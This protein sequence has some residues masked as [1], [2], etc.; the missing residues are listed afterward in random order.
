MVIDDSTEK[1]RGGDDVAS[2]WPDAAAVLGTPIDGK[3]PGTPRLG[4][5]GGSRSSAFTDKLLFKIDRHL[6]VP[7]FFLN[8]LSLMGRT[9]IGA[10]LIQ[11]LPQDLH[12]DAMG[13]FL[14]LTMPVAPLILCEVPS[15][16]LMR[17]LE[18]KWRFPYMRYLC[19]IDI[20]LGTCFSVAIKVC[21]S[22]HP[23]G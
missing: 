14:V 19:V 18:R 21:C 22:Q 5:G 13:V 3:D 2:T 16:L 10:A 11:K 1:P 6:L 17:D 8:F 23:Q 20:L 9:N 15:N 7:M 12:L 4:S